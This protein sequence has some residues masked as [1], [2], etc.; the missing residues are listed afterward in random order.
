MPVGP[1]VAVGPAQGVAQLMADDE[2]GGGGS[3][4]WPG[5]EV[6]PKVLSRISLKFSGQ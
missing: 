2:S 4:M 5:T 1:V 3:G 6:N